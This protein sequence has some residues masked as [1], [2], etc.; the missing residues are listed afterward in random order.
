MA[1]WLLRNRWV[2]MTNRPAVGH[3]CTGSIQARAGAASQSHRRRAI[4]RWGKN[5][6]ATSTLLGSEGAQG[7]PPTMGTQFF[8]HESLGWFSTRMT[9]LG[10]PG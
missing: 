7:P 1:S 9:I 2:G 6:W 5:W 10:S 4:V 8:C 3:R